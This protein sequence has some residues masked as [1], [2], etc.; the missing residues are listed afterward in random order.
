MKCYLTELL[1]NYILTKKFHQSLTLA[2]KTAL[3]T[4]HG[5]F[6]APIWY[7]QLRSR[8]IYYPHLLYN[9]PELFNKIDSLCIILICSTYYIWDLY[10][11]GQCFVLCTSVI[12]LTKED[13]LDFL[14][15]TLLVNYGNQGATSLPRIECICRNKTNPRRIKTSS[16]QLEP[17]VWLILKL[18]NCIN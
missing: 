17:V 8:S 5:N 11:N 12:A 4:L 6:P 14:S 16:K 3:L 10:R 1:G 9:F 15:L 18:W 2:E 7:K 13:E